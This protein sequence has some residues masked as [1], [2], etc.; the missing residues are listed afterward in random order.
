MNKNFFDIPVY[1]TSEHAYYEVRDTKIKASFEKSWGKFGPSEDQFEK[2]RVANEDHHFRTYGPWRFNEIIGYIRLYFLSTQIRGEYFSAEKKR[3]GLS[4]NRVFKF[5]TD[6]LAIE[7]NLWRSQSNEEIFEEVVS[8]LDRCEK[9]LNKNR[10]VDRK[11]LLEIGRFVDWRGM[12]GWEP[13]A[14]TRSK[15]KK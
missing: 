6:K 2:Y 5:Q 7:K 10:Y 9:E 13:K 1:R 15:A 4:R 3:N 11:V 12:L 14:I 8:Y